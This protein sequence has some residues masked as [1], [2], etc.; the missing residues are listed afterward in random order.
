MTPADV[1]SALAEQGQQ[2]AYTTVMTVLSRLVERGA[3]SRERVGRAFAYTAIADEAEL[4]ARR[5]TQLLASGQ[6][7]AAVLARFVDV[8]TDE[9]ERV[10]TERLARGRPDTGRSAS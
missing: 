5:M 10:L 7:R 8:L 1:R 3:A 2:L 9:D 4:T 6:D